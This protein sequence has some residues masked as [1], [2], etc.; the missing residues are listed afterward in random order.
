M[1][2]LPDFKALF[3]AAPAPYLVLL[4]DTPHFT[5]AEANRS[6]CAITQSD[7]SDLVGKGLFEAFPENAETQNS[8]GGLNLR[9][10]LEQVIATRASHKMDVQKYDI[11]VRGSEA[12]ET[13]YWLP[14]SFPV[15]DDRGEVSYIIH[16]TADVTNQMLAEATEKKTSEELL[17][18]QEHY[19][20]LFNNNPDAVFSFDLNG[21]FLSANQA[22]TRMAE[23]SMEEIMELTFVPFIDPQDLDR[24]FSHFERAGTGEIQ[25]Y[26]TR[27]IT[28]RGN[29]IIINV[30]N[31]PITVNREI[32]GVYGIAKDITASLRAE[33]QLKQSQNEMQKILDYSLDIICAL[34]ENRNFIKVNQACRKLWGYEPEELEGKS[35]FDII[36][37]EDRKPTRIKSDKIKAGINAGP[38]EN[39]IV[40]KD[41]RLVTMRWSSSWDTREKINY[42]VGRDVTAEKEAVEIIKNNEK[43]FQTLLKNSTD[44]LVLLSADGNFCEISETGK[45]IMGRGESELIGRAGSELVHPDDHPIVNQAF[46]NAREQEK[47]LQSVE[48]RILMPCG[49]HKWIEGNFQNQL[50]EPSIKAIVN[51]F[52]DITERKKVQDI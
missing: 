51:N 37:E 29:R 14:E 34:D 19:H 27:V 8:N 12:F 5:I 31:I 3:E 11:P 33:Q 13:R 22:L 46:K 21:Y 26:N 50:N 20:S 24:V 52:R 6:Y 16:T 1:N 17:R 7:R 15:L 10:S 35:I 23:C 43:R 18:S 38:I 45:K 48:Y 2:N 4:P 9:N 28:A 47:S 42:S 25:N 32:V 40:C 49:N 44:G 39:R 36:L 41:G 30:T